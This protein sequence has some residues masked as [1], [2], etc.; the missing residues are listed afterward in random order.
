MKRL[1]GT[2]FLVALLF[3]TCAVFSA[4]AIAASDTFIQPYSYREELPV[5]Y[6][7]W[8]SYRYHEEERNFEYKSFT[9]LNGYYRSETSESMEL[10]PLEYEFYA[11]AKKVTVH[12]TFY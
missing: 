9:Y 3:T 10:S 4:S 12:Y 8:Y 5:S 2:F 6:E 1:M 11:W 7:I